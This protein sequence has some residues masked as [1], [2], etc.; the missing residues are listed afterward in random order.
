[1]EVDKETGRGGGR[2]DEVGKTEVGKETG[3]SGR[4]EDEVGKDGGR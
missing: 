1:M 4:R 2:E 3:R